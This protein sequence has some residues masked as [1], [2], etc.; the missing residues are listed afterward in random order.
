MKRVLSVF[1]V[2]YLI[3]FMIVTNKQNFKHRISTITNSAKM[4]F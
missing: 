1:E 4:Q 3:L 2:I